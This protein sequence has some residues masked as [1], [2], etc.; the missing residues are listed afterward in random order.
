MKVTNHDPDTIR[1]YLLC[2][3]TDE[4]LVR[5]IDEN[6]LGDERYAEKIEL[7]EDALIEDYL[8]KALPDP[9]KKGF[10]ARLKNSA[11]F[12]ERV[13]LV[14][15][16][17]KAAARQAAVSATSPGNSWWAFDRIF[18]LRF[19]VILI[20]MTLVGFAVWRLAFI[21]NDT[22]I[23][24]ND[25]QKAVSGQRLTLGRTRLDSN[26]SPVITTRGAR[27]S[28]DRSSPSFR[29]AKAL[30]LKA[31]LDQPE[32]ADVLHLL[33]LMYLAEQDLERA[34]TELQKADK[35]DPKKAVLSADIGAV[36][37]EKAQNNQPGQTA[38]DRTRDLA[39]ALEYTDR[40][41]TADPNRLETLFNRA[42]ILEEMGLSIQAKKAWEEYLAKD[43]NS[44]WSAEARKHLESIDQDKTLSRSPAVILQDFWAAR[45]IRDN[46]RAWQIIGETKELI[47]GSL[48]FLQLSKSYIDA[49]TAG[50]TGEAAR[51]LDG[52]AFIAEIEAQ[53]TSDKF[54][55][56]LYH[57]YQTSASRNR[58]KLAAAN[59]QMTNGYAAAIDS[60]NWPV[61]LTAFNEAK[62]M[63]LE[64]GDPWEAEIAEFQ[65]CYVLTQRLKVS[66]SS[67]R[68]RAVAG[69]SSAN[70][71]TWI[72]S[73]ANGWLGSN[74]ALDGEYSTAIGFNDR[75]LSE[76]RSAGDPYGAQKAASQLTSQYIQL[77]NQDR[78]LE[79]IGEMS[80]LLPKYSQ[81]P[82]QRSRNLL[83]A[84]QGFFRFGYIAASAA[85]TEEQLVLAKETLKDAWL[86]HT[87]H[88]NRA[89]V[90]S[91][92]GKYEAAL[93]DAEECFRLARVFPDEGMRKR[94]ELQSRLLLADIQRDGD[95]CTEAVES[96]D[97]VIR[98]LKTSEFAASLY[99]A[100]KGRLMC[101]AKLG[102][103]DEV[104]AEM[105][106]VTEIFEQNRKTIEDETDRNVFFQSEQSVYD[107]GSEY[108][109]A[110]LND[111]NL[112]FRY[113]E[114]S[115][116]NS[117]LERMSGSSELQIDPAR[118]QS[119]IPEGTCV[120]FYSVLSERTLV[121]VIGRDR[122][123][124]VSIDVTQDELEKLVG[125]YSE[126]IARKAYSADLAHALYG[127]LLEP[128]SGKFKGI[129][130]LCIVPDKSLFGLSF[131]ALRSERA[132]KY[133]I[134][135]FELMYSPGVR[136]FDQLT[137]SSKER[138]ET[139]KDRFVGIGASVFNRSENPAV[140]E[141]GEVASEV[142]EIA[143]SYPSSTV[144]TANGV[145]KAAVLNNLENSET[146]HFAGHYIANRK[147]PMRSRFLLADSDLA[148]SELFSEGKAVPQL[149]VLSAC[150][151]GIE[152][153]YAGEGMIGASRA[154]LAAGVPLVIGSQWAVDSAATAELM[155]R[156]HAKRTDNLS[157]PAAL[158]AAQI[159]ML[160]NPSEQ[161]RE[162]FYW[163]GF[164]PV[165]GSSHS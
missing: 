94:L 111:E 31:E 83:F 82:R 64:A 87:A 91:R 50:S 102:L 10:E 126:S 133:L 76:A 105:S 9:E 96:Y 90:F 8:E 30:L 85:V 99:R 12:R 161:K 141:I 124:V 80:E 75:A 32:N 137:A 38:G 29:K 34:L 150:E 68:L 45:D 108:A 21:K 78:V 98:D 74:Y 25:L 154:F 37:L 81:S 132:G 35:L 120:L 66:E 52:L 107:I 72:A 104:I 70:H 101:V 69:R 67:D 156:F 109:Y 147:Q 56:E 135:E 152:R 149:V 93:A 63:Y 5:E 121:W 18:V 92:L 144:L 41:L 106:A 58:E 115:R 53:H 164:I 39:I 151:S 15:A 27:Q 153:Y 1:R 143:K 73:L 155:I 51:A 71:H 110:K 148:V 49:E 23:A 86:T 127:L 19:A 7:V 84:S 125:S 28:V 142:V 146:F 61:A 54:F 17:R 157:P 16:L 140:D 48:V 42:L 33:G 57:Y 113:S 40:S 100:R 65:I 6:M 160:N 117:L 128:V 165:G 134:E 11:E 118:L 112:A 139:R 22:E 3:L 136:V 4:A 145:T 119:G 95:N 47:S 114:G 44:E 89:N 2:E 43:A 26:Y 116:A 79:T 162:P 163:A 13:A 129:E 62:A 88:L 14:S 24:F 130:L 36:Y 97:R 55:P 123:D 60:A 138:G 159:E 59:Q 20:A 77:G 131:A 122:W 46:E 103:D 158:R